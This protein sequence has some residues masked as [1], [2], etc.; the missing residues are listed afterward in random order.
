MNTTVTFKPD[1][2]QS[3]SN[4]AKGESTLKLN[5]SKSQSMPSFAERLETTEKQV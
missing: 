3:K 2:E 1:I 5:M 4:I